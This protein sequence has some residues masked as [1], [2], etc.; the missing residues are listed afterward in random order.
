VKFVPN[1]IFLIL[2]SI[3]SHLVFNARGIKLYSNRSATSGS[4]FV[5]RRAGM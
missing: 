5:A 1:L 4:T 3:P 2:A